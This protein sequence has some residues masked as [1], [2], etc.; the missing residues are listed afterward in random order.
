[1]PLSPEEEQKLRDDAERFRKE[2]ETKTL[3]AAQLQTQLDTLNGQMQNNLLQLTNTKNDLAKEQQKLKDCVDQNDQARVQLR[4]AREETANVT[5]KLAAMELVKEELKNGKSHRRITR[6]DLPED[7]RFGGTADES[8]KSFLQKYD[9]QAE[10]LDM[11]PRTKAT[12]LA[13]LLTKRAAIWYTGL[14]SKTQLSYEE[15]K[16]L[17]LDHFDDSAQA[18]FRKIHH[19]RSQLAAESVEDY[20]TAIDSIALKCK[21]T[22]EEKLETFVR[23]LRPKIKAYV[24]DKAPSNFQTAERFAR[25][26]ENLFGST[27]VKKVSRP[28]PQTNVNYFDTVEPFWSQEDDEDDLEEYL[29]VVGP[30]GPADPTRRPPVYQPGRQDTSMGRCTACN[31]SGHTLRFCPDAYCKIC[32]APGHWTTSCSRQNVPNTP[33]RNPPYNGPRRLFQGDGRRYNRG[34]QQ[35]SRGY[36]QDS[37]NQQQ[38]SRGF[39]QGHR[40]YHPGNRRNYDPDRD[41]RR[42]Q[43]GDNYQDRQQQNSASYNDQRPVD[44]PQRSSNNRDPTVN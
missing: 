24:M 2:L 11:D 17:L 23:G 37:R 26:W 28:S 7:L 15:V 25:Q 18:W 8:V 21:M 30:Q 9:V 33:R 29:Q 1:M 4:E 22:P 38:E 6:S 13:G 34:Y 19:E 16:K 44:T 41:F 5:S 42:D 20:S 36:E 39:Q 43:R 40:R 10:L 12:I 3:H 27:E 35:D 32:K 14:D 31:L